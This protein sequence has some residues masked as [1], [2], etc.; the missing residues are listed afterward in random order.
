M[1]ITLLLALLFLIPVFIV[2]IVRPGG[3]A[4]TRENMSV[5]IEKTAT[6][7]KI[8]IKDVGGYPNF[9]V[10]SDRRWDVWDSKNRVT[11]ATGILTN[12]SSIV[13]LNDT[14]L[15]TMLDVGDI[16]VVENPAHTYG[17][18]YFILHEDVDSWLPVIH[19]QFPV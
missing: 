8:V 2:F 17:G 10:S 12:S 6:G 15:N 5:D 13:K 1:L 19:V 4:I 11:I 3:D 14:N 16:I 18:Y 7:Y 9:T